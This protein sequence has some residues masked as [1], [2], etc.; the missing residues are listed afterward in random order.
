LDDKVKED[1]SSVISGAFT[2]DLDSI[3]PFAAICA[4]LPLTRPS[5][6]GADADSINIECLEY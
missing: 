2:A 1:N 5:Y 3:I 6:I 4:M